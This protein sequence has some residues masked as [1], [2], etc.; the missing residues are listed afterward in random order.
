M[1]V[2][3]VKNLCIMRE[4]QTKYLKREMEMKKLVILAIIVL[5][6][7]LV[8]CSVNDSSKNE[9]VK[10]V[11]HSEVYSQAM[12]EIIA[13]DSAY[14]ENMTGEQVAYNNIKTFAKLK[15]TLVEA[16]CYNAAIEK[17][18]FNQNSIELG[19]K[20]ADFN[21]MCLIAN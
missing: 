4:V 2:V 5:N 17:A 7:L 19:Y 8:A 16:G 20:P 9:A 11:N 15:N 12:T 13:S 18:Y 1:Y 14:A 6:T 10:P 3:L 21:A